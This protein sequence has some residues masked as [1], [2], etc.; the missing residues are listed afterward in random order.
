MNTI[1]RRAAILAMGGLAA[2]ALLA[3]CEKKPQPAARQDL[4]RR[5]GRLVE[6]MDKYAEPK[7][8][9]PGEVEMGKPPADPAPPTPTTTAPPPLPKPAPADPATT[10][11]RQPEKP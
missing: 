1:H 4:E 9:P 5:S 11:A 3:A 7:A 10:P 8:P 6:D 2:C